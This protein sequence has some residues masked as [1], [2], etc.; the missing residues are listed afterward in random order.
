MGKRQLILLLATISTVAFVASCAVVRSQRSLGVLGRPCE[1]AGKSEIT[2]NCDYSPSFVHA[3]KQ[4]RR[5]ALVHA[6]VRFHPNDEGK[7]Q[8]ELTFKNIGE[9]SLREADTVYIEFDDGAGQNYIRRPL[10]H[11]DFRQLAPGKVKTFTDTLLAPA[12]LP[13]R[14]IVRLWIPSSNA[15]DRF[16]ARRDLLLGG[17]GV[18]EPSTG[19]NRVATIMV[20]R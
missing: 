12:L 3:G 4:K 13:N 10:P 18:A 2:I 17:A 15:A 5:I 1:A 20:E 19:L 9:G 16:D 6:F 7:M 11:V 8:I 14:Y